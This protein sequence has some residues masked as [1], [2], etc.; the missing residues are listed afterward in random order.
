MNRLLA[1]AAVACLAACSTPLQDRNDR[2]APS[3]RRDDRRDDRRPSTGAASQTRN[4]FEVEGRLGVVGK[5][6]LGID[7]SITVM[8]NDGPPARL[9]VA[10]GTQIMLDDRPARLTDLREG[11]EVRATFDFDDS[12]PV[13][14][15]LEAKQH[16]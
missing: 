14:L 4:P 2:N 5:G 1:A 13:L 15:K 11:D 6:L 10:D 8:R 3:A 9:H 16:R 12:T 7:R